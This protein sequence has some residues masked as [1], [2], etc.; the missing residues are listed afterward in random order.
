MLEELEQDDLDDFEPMMPGSDDEFSDLE[1]VEDNDDDIAPQPHLPPEDAPSSTSGTLP[2]WTSTLSPVTI[3]PFSSPVGPT[4]DIPQSPVDILDLMFTPDLVDNMVEQSNLYAKEVMGE[5]R[6]ECWSK[7]TRE[8]LRAYLGFCILMGINHLPALDD[9]WSKDPSLRYSA[10]VDRIT[11]DR[12]RDIT[13]YLHFVDNA[14]LTPRGSPGHDRLGKVRPV[15]DHLSSRFSD[16]YEPHQEVAVDEAMIKFTG[17][18]TLEQ[19]MPM[20]PVK[21]G[22]NVWALADS[23]NGYFHKF[24]LYTGKESGGE[25]QLGHRIVKDLTDHLKG[26]GHHV[27]FDNFFTSQKLLCD[28][29]EDDIFACG[30]ARKDRRG[31]P[32]A[33]KS[34]K[35][36]NRSVCMVYMCVYIHVHVC[37][38]M[39]VCMYENVCIN[40]HKQ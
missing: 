40:I 9:Y 38:Y 23:H 10:I 19:Y 4:V 5:E 18:S 2:G 3:P 22:I 8:E 11:R 31:F 39:C 36:K 15:I 12:F 30:T 34:L 6:Y 13:R 29:A 33:L 21:R 27:Y 14:T 16:L 28:L 20:K 25:K 32:P 35:L 37:R 1:D 7:I 24:Q 26:K 17:R